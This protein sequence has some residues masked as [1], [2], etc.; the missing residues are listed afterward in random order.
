MVSR[1]PLQAATPGRRVLVLSGGGSRGAL[2]VGF[3][4]ALW[5]G[6]VPFDVIVGSSVGALNG[7]FLA[8]GR[9]PDDLAE[10][11]R[12]L[13]FRDLFRMN[14][15]ELL[16]RGMGARSI[17]R[18]GRRLRRLL[19]ALP[20]RFEELAIPF[21]AVATDLATG[22]PVAF[23]QGELLPALLVSCPRNSLTI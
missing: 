9:T 22:A 6:G 13:R 2:D 4:Q 19:A 16:A 10:A 3:T 12:P 5:S 8:S 23:D 14:W 20:R 18:V 1:H 7:A 11:W 15:P 17:Y 21:V